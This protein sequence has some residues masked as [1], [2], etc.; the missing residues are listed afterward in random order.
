ML[1]I[2]GRRTSFNVQKVMW[3]VG[4]LGLP[5]EHIAAG[6]RFGRLND[7]DFRA[8]NPHGRIPLIDDDGQIVW[9]SHTILRYIASRYGQGSFWSDD[10]GRRADY[11]AWMDWAQ[12]ALQPSFLNDIFWGFYRTPEAQRDWQIINRGIARCAD[13]FRLLDGWLEGRAFMLGD[14][15]SLA[16]ITVGTTLFRYFNIDLARP[17]VPRV[18]AWYER[19]TARPA[20]REHVMIPF[21]DVYGRLE[22]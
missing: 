8:M 9:E 22:H 1:R 18:E 21:D 5:H 19:L 3:L 20:Y 10:A 17:S 2:W 11:E 14:A 6:G 16:D 13:H 15:I 12:T 7:A 4:E